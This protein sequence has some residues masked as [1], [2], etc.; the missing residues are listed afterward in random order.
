MSKSQIVKGSTVRLRPDVK[1]HVCPPDREN[2]KTAVVFAVLSEGR[3][4]LEQD[5]VGCKWWNVTDVE[6]V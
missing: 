1:H 2:N 4:H 3:L 6:L 5:L